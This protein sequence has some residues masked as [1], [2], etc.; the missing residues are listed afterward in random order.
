MTSDN[1]HSD[2]R[3]MI[4]PYVKSSPEVRNENKVLIFKDNGNLTRY[5]LGLNL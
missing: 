1:F 4:L 3:L 5:N 2:D